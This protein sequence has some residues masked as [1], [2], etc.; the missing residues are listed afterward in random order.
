MLSEWLLRAGF[1]A[2][3]RRWFC[4][5]DGTV[6]VEQDAAWDDVATGAAQDRK[7]IASR[8]GVADGVVTSYRRH[9]AGLQ[10]ALDA[11]DLTVADEVTRSA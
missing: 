9:D 6:V 2:S 3:A 10:E 1:S 7:R 8:F 11:G 4:G 5:A